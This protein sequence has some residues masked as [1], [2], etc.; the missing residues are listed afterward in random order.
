VPD[1]TI[2]VVE[3]NAQGDIATLMLI[4]NEFK[5]SRV[6]Y[7]ATVS[8]IATQAAMK[9]ITDRPIVFGA[10]ANPYI[11]GA[12]TSPTEHRPHV[13]GAAI[14]LPVDSTLALGQD[15]PGDRRLGTP[16]TRPTCSRSSISKGEDHR[17][18]PGVKFWRCV[19]L[20]GRHRAGHPGAGGAGRLEHPQIPSVM[21]GGRSRRRE[22]RSGCRC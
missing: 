1:S 6:G 2:T 15:L 20:A 22:G 16:T 19:H 3:R 10:V 7:V 11:I 4:M 5:M 9:V 17:R 14:P 21:I 18:A 13:T 8:S 12:G